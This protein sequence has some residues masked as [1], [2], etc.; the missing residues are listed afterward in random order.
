MSNKIACVG[1]LLAILLLTGCED[2]LPHGPIGPVGPTGPA[3]PAD[4]PTGPTG[5]EGPQGPVGPPGPEITSWEY[6]IAEEDVT[7]GL[8]FSVKIVDSRF[9]K[10]DWIDAW[11]EFDGMKM[12]VFPYLDYYTEAW[13]WDFAY[14][15]D[16]L[17]F[18]SIGNPTG[19]KLIFYGV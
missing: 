14:E 17:Y 13:V 9:A 16:T 19:M 12:R 5:T 7:Y 18:Y 1:I 4:G 2:M 6:V 8:P 10:F 11:H 3:G 15:G